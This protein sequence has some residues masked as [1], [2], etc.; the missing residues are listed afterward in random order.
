MSDGGTGPNLSVEL[1]AL[2]TSAALAVGSGVALLADASTRAA[3]FAFILSALAFLL[4]IP[5][6]L[7]AARNRRRPPP[8]V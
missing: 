4:C 3:W 7:I 2:L 5:L 6:V 8:D 1:G